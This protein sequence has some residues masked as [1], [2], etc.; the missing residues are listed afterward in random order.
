M[1]TFGISAP[2]K[3]VQ[4]EKGMTVEAVVAAARPPNHWV[5]GELGNL[6][7]Y[8]HEQ[9]IWTFPEMVVNHQF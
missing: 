5:F 1:I 6:L 8:V 4:T 7:M 2:I 3:K 9:T